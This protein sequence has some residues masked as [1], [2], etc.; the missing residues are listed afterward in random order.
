MAGFRFGLMG[1]PSLEDVAG[2]FLGTVEILFFGSE[3]TVFFSS[4]D[5]VFFGCVTI[6]AALVDLALITISFVADGF[7]R[8][9]TVGSGFGSAF[10]RDFGSGLDSST[11]DAARF[12]TGF[13]SSVSIVV[14]FGFALLAEAAVADFAV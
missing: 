3:V 12:L 8:V 5:M 10:L 4:V 9:F 13:A 2:A 11:L 1:L 7:V 14:V 6:S